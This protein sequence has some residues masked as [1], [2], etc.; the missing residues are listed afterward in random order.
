MSVVASSPT[1]K[2][3]I[4]SNQ[5]DPI[6][7]LPTLTVQTNTQGPNVTLNISM[8]LQGLVFGPDVAFSY[9]FATLRAYGVDYLLLDLRAYAQVIRFLHSQVMTSVVFQNS[10]VVILRI[11]HS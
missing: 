5:D 2:V 11:P 4:G 10:K 1:G 7:S 6:T 3:Q 8:N 9:A